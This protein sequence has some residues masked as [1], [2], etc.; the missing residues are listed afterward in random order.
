MNNRFNINES[1]KNRKLRNIIKS[2][3]RIIEQEKEILD[4]ED[5]NGF[6]C[7]SC[8]TDVLEAAKISNPTQIID[9]LKLLFRPDIIMDKMI[10]S[11]V[12]LIN[13][14]SLDESDSFLTSTALL[15]CI[16]TKECSTFVPHLIDDIIAIGSAP[17]EPL[18]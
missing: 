11:V 13:S 1:E 16:G 3:I 10:Q 7:V 9:D 6:A 15:T 17:E 14:T 4:W 2:N 12:D 5:D 18:V 8:F